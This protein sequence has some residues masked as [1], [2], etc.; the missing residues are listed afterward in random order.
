MRQK[1]NLR[2]DTVGLEQ[3]IYASQENFYTT[4][5]CDG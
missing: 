4:A 5:G 2:Q 3:Q 1:M